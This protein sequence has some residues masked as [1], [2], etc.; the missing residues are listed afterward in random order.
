MNVFAL[1]GKLIPWA[2]GVV[3][4]LLTIIGVLPDWWPTISSFVL[5]LAQLLISL[6]PKTP[7]V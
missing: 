3:A 1:V 2:V 4:G 6:G 5:G 7:A